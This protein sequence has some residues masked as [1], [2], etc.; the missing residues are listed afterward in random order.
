MVI[1]FRLFISRYLNINN[2]CGT[3][4]NFVLSFSLVQL[5]G[6]GNEEEYMLA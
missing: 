5:D 1:D 6:I 3:L 4:E 2:P